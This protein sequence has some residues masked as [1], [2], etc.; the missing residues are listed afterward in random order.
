MFLNLLLQSQCK[1]WMHI[2]E[3][4]FVYAHPLSRLNGRDNLREQQSSTYISGGYHSGAN[5][6]GSAGFGYSDPVRSGNRQP[7]Q[8]G[9][10]YN[11]DKMGSVSCFQ[12][13]RSSR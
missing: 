8:D 7:I 11:L 1:Y 3:H 10:T 13:V 5:Q 12:S 4:M 2:P 9:G 6:I